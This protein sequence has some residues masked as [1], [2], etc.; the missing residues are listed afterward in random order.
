VGQ[1]LCKREGDVGIV[2]AEISREAELPNTDGRRGAQEKKQQRP[3]AQ[4]KSREFHGHR[5]VN[6]GDG[7]AVQSYDDL[8]D[9]KVPFA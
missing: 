3:I 4:R 7:Y 6:R 1:I 5:E 8:T 9:K 2:D